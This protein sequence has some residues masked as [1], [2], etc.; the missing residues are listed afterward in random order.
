M[1]SFLART[2]AN[3]QVRYVP[4]STTSGET[5]SKTKEGTTT[6]AG[7]AGGTTLVDASGDSGV[8]DTYNGQYWV[9]ILSGACLGEQ[10]RIIDDNGTGTLTVETAFSAQIAGSVDYVIRKS[11][12]PVVLVTTGDSTTSFTAAARVEAASTWVG[13]YLCPVGGACSGEAPKLISAQTALGVFT[14]AAF[15]ATPAAGDTFLLAKFL[16]VEC[17]PSGLTSAFT[18]RPGT[19]LG[20]SH[21]DG[22]VGVKSGSLT[23]NLPIRPSGTLA[24]AEANANLAEA[25]GLMQAIGLEEVIGKTVTIDAT[26]ASASA[27]LIATGDRENLHI[28][29]VVIWNGNA[30]RVASLGDG[31]AGADTMNVVPAFPAV[32]VSG[33]LVRGTRTYKKSTT[34]GNLLGVCIEIEVDGV[35]HTCTGCKGNASLATAGSLDLAFSFQVDEWVKDP[36]TAGYVADDAYSTVPPVLANDCEFYLDNTA[37]GMSGFTATPGAVASPKPIPGKDGAN[38][39]AGFEITSYACSATFDTLLNAAADTLPEELRYTARTAKAL[40]AVFGSGGDIFA[41]TIPVARM[42]A[43]PTT[44]A[45]ENMIGAPHVLSADYAGTAL[46]NTT[47]ERVPDFAFHLS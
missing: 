24:A 16:G 9:K 2:F 40:L 28:G 41:V 45:V 11:P 33:D 23:F 12:E 14:F 35:R 31:G 44:K 38:G 15:V 25:G 43:Q 22:V 39:R 37:T 5:W 34:P 30:R 36:S 20:H 13:Y 19:R 42:M 6:G 47:Y 21:G 26:N 32:P 29:Q 3:K 1:S 4:H 10:R 8:A 27:V 7:N 18:P 17:D 46:N